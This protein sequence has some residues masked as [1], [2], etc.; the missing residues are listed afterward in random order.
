MK[1]TGEENDFVNTS[2][3]LN[4]HFPLQIF[5]LFPLYF[6]TLSYVIYLCYNAKIDG[7]LTMA[8]QTGKKEKLESKRT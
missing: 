5:V 1:V 3:G 4:V 7:L 6:V 2:E 8:G